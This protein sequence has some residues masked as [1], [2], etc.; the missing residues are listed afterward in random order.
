MSDFLIVVH[1]SHTGSAVILQWNDILT[2]AAVAVTLPTLDLAVFP[3]CYLPR[4]LRFREIRLHP[5]TMAVFLLGP[6]LWYSNDQG[7]SFQSMFIPTSVTQV[8][9]WGYY[10]KRGWQV[11]VTKTSQ[12]KCHGFNPWRTRF[13]SDHWEWLLTGVYGRCRPPSTNEKPCGYWLK[14]Y[15]AGELIDRAWFR[16]FDVPDQFGFYLLCIHLCFST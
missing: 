5:C 16:K 2:Q 14:Y 8:R 4:G 10:C 11:C 15:F 1:N 7:A 3:I 6:E 12:S 9:K 13:H